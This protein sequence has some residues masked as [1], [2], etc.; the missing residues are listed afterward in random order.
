MDEKVLALLHKEGYTEVKSLGAGAFASVR[1]S[2]HV[3]CY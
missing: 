1:R 3:W 2:A